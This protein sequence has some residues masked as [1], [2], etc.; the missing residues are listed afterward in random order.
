[1]RAVLIGVLV[2]LPTAAVAQNA[3]LV[4]LTVPAE[5][6]PVG[7]LLSPTPSVKL[8]GNRYRGGL[9]AGLPSN[10][11]I[12]TDS[13]RIASIASIFFPS[14][15]MPDGPPLD[16]K[17]MALFRLHFADGIEEGYEA[18]Y[19]TDDSAPFII[20]YGLRFPT[21]AA[22]QSF[23]EQSGFAHDRR[24]AQTGSVVALAAGPESAC[25]DVVLAH[26]QS[27]AR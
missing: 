26:V 17:E 15:R 7:C 10:P 24:A 5:R 16:K 1:M 22:A 8:E 3:R 25:F 20:V 18:V 14:I 11:W 23:F 12:G 19:L 13:V 9:W 6:L 21:A 4:D 2:L 27:F